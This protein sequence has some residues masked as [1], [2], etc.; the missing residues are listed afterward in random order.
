MAARDKNVRRQ[1]IVFPSHFL[2][3]CINF[4]HCLAEIMVTVFGRPK[5]GRSRG[6]A[7]ATESGS[8]I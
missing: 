4:A 8:A 3:G 1:R 6:S 2:D 7:K 5:G